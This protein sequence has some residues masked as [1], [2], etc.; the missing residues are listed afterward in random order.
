VP[1]YSYISQPLQDRKTE[2]FK[3]ALAKGNPRK[4][5]AARQA[6]A[7]PTGSKRASFTALQK[8]LT[9]DTVLVH[10]NLERFLFCDIDA[11]KKRGIGAVVYHIKG[12]L[13]Q[14][15]IDKLP[16]PPRTKVEL[17]MFLSRALKD[18]KTRY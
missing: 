2:L 11:S 16:Y 5:F 9:A 10:G 14:D 17:I 3:R 6:F 15:S 7:Y 12:D 8:A 1:F 4:T 13:P 18:A